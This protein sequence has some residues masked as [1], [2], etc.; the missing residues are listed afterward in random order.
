MGFCQRVVCTTPTY[1]MAGLCVS[2]FSSAKNGP[3]LIMT[4]KEIQGVIPHQLTLSLSGAVK[5]V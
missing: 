3:V 4:A 2:V 5:N 1:N